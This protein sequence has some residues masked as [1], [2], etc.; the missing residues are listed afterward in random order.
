MM[1]DHVLTYTLPAAYA[2]LPPA[3]AS[4]GASAM[5]LAIGLQESVFAER[6]QRPGPARGFWQFEGGGGIHGVLTHRA[7]R[8][9]IGEALTDLCYPAAPHRRTRAALLVAVEHNDVLAAVFARL[10]LW[11]LPDP[12]P[13]PDQA[14]AAWAQYLAAWNPGQPHPDTWPAYFAEAW[15][16]VIAA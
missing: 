16:R 7:T 15:T 8:A 11:T 13:A 3:M 10:L 14:D 6:R 9:I 5:L 2:V 12:V 1:I 4:R